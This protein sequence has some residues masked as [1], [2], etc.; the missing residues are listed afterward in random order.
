MKTEKFTVVSED[1]EIGCRLVVPDSG[2][3]KIGAVCITGGTS[4]A[5]SLY[6]EWQEYFASEGITTV[7]FDARGIGESEGEWDTGK[8]FDPRKS[9][10]SQASRVTDTLEV[11]RSFARLAPECVGQLA[12]VG[13]SMGGDI[14][15]HAADQARRS[16]PVPDVEA[17]VL[18]APAAYHPA[19]HHMLYGERLRTI[20]RSDSQA[21]S[22]VLSTNFRILREL[23]VP[24]Q[25]IFARGEEVI[26]REI[27]ELYKL[28]VGDMPNSQ[29]LEVGRT[30]KTRHPYFR[31]LDKV[32]QIAKGRTFRRSAEFLLR[33]LT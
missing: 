7:A 26:D 14:A 18:K 21:Y 11:V 16:A 31:H 10:N 22:A 29:I 8:G 24:T 4:P 30:G 5:G 12:L 23:G 1:V 3:S 33:T 6:G 17:L 20:L 2:V 32:S 27:I 13:S 9:Y 28:T 15:I 25:L 19:A